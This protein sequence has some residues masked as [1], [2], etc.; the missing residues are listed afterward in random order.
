MSICWG[1]IIQN[2]PTWV[3]YADTN[4]NVE[5]YVPVIF[6]SD[7]SCGDCSS[8]EGPVD[9]KCP[10]GKVAQDKKP[11]YTSDKSSIIVEKEF[12]DLTSASASAIA[13]SISD[14]DISSMNT[15]KKR[16]S[17]I[18]KLA[19]IAKISCV[20]FL[21]L[22]TGVSYSATLSTTKNEDVTDEAYVF[23]STT[24]AS[25]DVQ[26]KISDLET[27]RSNASTA[28]SKT[29]T[30]DTDI[31]SLKGKAS[32]LESA[33][34]GFTNDVSSLK[35]RSDALENAANGF[36]NKISSLNNAA[37]GFTNDVSSLKSR[38]NNLETAASGFTNKISSL[39]GKA[40]SLE[41][42]SK[43]FTNSVSILQNAAKGFTNDITAIKARATSLES[44][45]SSFTNDII[46][47]KTGD[48]DIGKKIAAL[49]A[50]KLSAMTNSV[51]KG[52]ITID[53]GYLKANRFVL[54]YNTSGSFTGSPLYALYDL[55]THPFYMSKY[56]NKSYT[57][58]LS[59][60]ST[61][62]TKDDSNT[63][64]TLSD[65]KSYG[66]GDVETTGN[67]NVV[68]SVSK[69]SSSNKIT[70]TKGITALD[71]TTAASTYLSKTDASSTYQ[72]KGSYASQSDMTTAKNNIS[73]NTTALASL[74]NKVGTWE[75]FVSGSNVVFVIT[76]YQSNAYSDQVGKFKV[77]E[78]VTDGGTN[79]YR[80][81]Y[82]SHTDINTHLVAYKA[83]IIDPAL[84][85]KA[86]KA[87]QKYSSAG[88]DLEALGMSN[89]VYMT[90]AKTV[91]AGG[92]EFERVVVGQGS[93]GVLTTKGAAAYT[94]GE[95]GTF[96]IQ[97]A[98]SDNYFGYSKTDD[99]V[100]GCNTDN[101]TVSSSNLVC[102]EYDLISSTY[103]IIYYMQSLQNYDPTAWEQ[104]NDS[105]GNQI[106]GASHA[107]TFDT[108]TPEKFYVYI[109]C[110]SQPS[111]FFLAKI[112]VAGQST[113]ET[114]M[115]AS[116][117]KGILCTDGQHTIKFDYNNGSPKL[118]LGE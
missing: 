29:D 18:K 21:M 81:V 3:H 79:Y 67:G 26:E 100:I 52:S 101:I 108:S 23:T 33:A 7:P 85:K 2:G 90:A 92:L 63:L 6:N 75:E 24:N 111:G 116:F 34:S 70:A 56:N 57:W 58:W 49:E 98:T 32:N 68:T 103:P 88:T 64:A 80:E 118:I 110:S 31:T 72:A 53:D 42:A 11:Y 95:A 89:T 99:Y 13:N 14:T 25:L 28:K 27:I 47:L 50:S 19:A 60:P 84:D 86:D 59:T 10:L 113:F 107:V 106:S 94:T 104:L 36:T 112:T 16:N 65:V 5:E 8:C 4:P 45:A 77:L 38:A 43:G 91:F 48:S 69:D 96:K 30:H 37:L 117:S 74:D 115:K 73:A 54:D 55:N 20:A 41:N 62:T 93:I 105:D 44:A 78:L 66:V 109:D 22:L 39:E 35:R 102:L 1:K 17:M 83:D 114:N 97:D 46:S 82:N 15:D 40:T 51:S 87:W 61:S 76:N 12:V 71:T 9:G